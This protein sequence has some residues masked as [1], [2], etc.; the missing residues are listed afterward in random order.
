M[1][2]PLQLRNGNSRCA[3]EDGSHLQAAG[4]KRLKVLGRG[5]CERSPRQ[6]CGHG[7]CRQQPLRRVRCPAANL[8]LV[9]GPCSFETKETWKGAMHRPVSPLGPAEHAVPC[10]RQDTSRETHQPSRVAAHREGQLMRQGTPWNGSSK[11]SVSGT[12]LAG[13]GWR[14][15]AAN[16]RTPVAGHALGPLQLLDPGIECKSLV[17][18]PALGMGAAAG[19]PCDKAMQA[20]QCSYTGREQAGSQHHAFMRR[21]LPAAKEKHATEFVNKMQQAHD[22][23]AK[24]L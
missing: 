19:W 22:V 16:W 2:Q 8:L 20:G 18:S 21:M 17:K 6:R 5:L 14:A 13:P 10:V 11:T 23:P 9:L 1:T 4:F 12:H 3:Q 15:L 24:Q 7:T